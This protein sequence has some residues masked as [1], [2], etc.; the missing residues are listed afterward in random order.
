MTIV[1]SIETIRNWIEAHVCQQVELKL[2]DDNAAAETYPYKLV[3]PAAF[4][5]FVPGKDRLPP[6]VA[7]PIPSVCV[8]LLEGSD[9]LL[10]SKGRIRVR[11]VFSTWNPGQHGPDTLPPASGIDIHAVPATGSGSLEHDG[12]PAGSFT[13]NGDGWMDA[14][15]FVDVA[16]REL[17]AAEYLDGL[18][19]IKEEG[20]AFGPLT[21]QDAIV[22]YY[23]YWF[24]WISF[25]VQ[26]GI[27]RTPQQL[28]DLL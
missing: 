2:P 18:R 23:P 14:W 3:K 1:Q 12:A 20:I 28:N 22:D 16:L 9:S 13:R 11:L 17:E 24:A 5:L 8:Q 6:S 21:E 26:Y 15:G 19:I 4:A 25:S 7:A 10:E 27:A